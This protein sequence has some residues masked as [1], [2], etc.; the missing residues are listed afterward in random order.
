MLVVG[1][2]VS[3]IF[4]FLMEFVYLVGAVYLCGSRSSLYDDFLIAYSPSE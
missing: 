4:F 1:I 2:E 3:V